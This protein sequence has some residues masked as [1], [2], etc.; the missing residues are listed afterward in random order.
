MSEQDQVQPPPPLSPVPNALYAK[1][2]P[3]LIYAALVIIL[4]LSGTLRLIDLENKPRWYADE[5]FNLKVIQDLMEGHLRIRAVSWTAFSPFHPYPI[6]YHLC[7]TVF[8]A[9]FGDSLWTVR[10]MCG[11]IGVVTTFLIFLCGK[12]V[13][14]DRAG[15]IAATAYSLH[16][17][18]VLF[19]RMAFPQNLS[20]LVVTAAI[21]GVMKFLSLKEQPGD[22]LPGSS[23]RKSGKILTSRTNWLTAG[24]LLVGVSTV[25][26]Y[27]AG[28]LWLWLLVIVGLTERKRLPLTAGL[29]VLPLLLQFLIMVL[30]HGF[31]PVLYDIGQLT[32]VRFVEADAKATGL[33]ERLY[34]LMGGYYH[35]FV[36]DIVFFLGLFGL[37]NLPRRSHAYALLTALFLLSFPPIAQRGEIVSEFFYNAVMFAPLPCIGFGAFCGWL[38]HLAGNI[39]PVIQRTWARFGANTLVVAAL[40]F[41]W[42]FSLRDT[43]DLKDW[44]RDYQTALD[45]RGLSMESYF[46]A[47]AVAYFINE[48]TKE[49][50]F[51]IASPNLPALL[52]CNSTG[53]HQMASRRPGGTIWYPKDLPEDRYLYSIELKD[54]KFF[55]SDRQTMNFYLTVKNCE[56]V[57]YEIHREG[58]PKVHSKG[59]FQVFLNPRFELPAERKGPP[60]RIPVQGQ[61]W[62]GALL[63]RR[64]NADSELN[65]YRRALEEGGNEAVVIIQGFIQQHPNPEMLK[66]AL[67]EYKSREASQP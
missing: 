46:A 4:L 45:K 12:T 33:G 18:I 39:K 63:G 52:N 8:C 49:D 36:L 27:W 50:D 53:V 37:A 7:G 60:F 2:P 9:V 15:L 34:R 6:G 26:I 35:V 65:W 57:L 3:K 19:T 23:S 31:G 11:I 24:A 30:A 38:L 29:L 67:A 66:K 41:G 14:D 5:L 16:P 61:V 20:P 22:E 56:E 58:W 32:G 44:P 51:V 17:K 55:V 42:L 40:G 64:G 48:N 21:L 47:Q 59:E 43:V 28:A 54:A 10:F 25:S 62:L 13:F 1:L